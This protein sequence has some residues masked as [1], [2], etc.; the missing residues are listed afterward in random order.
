MKMKMKMKMENNLV[1]IFIIFL[2]CLS[3]VFIQLITPHF[4]AKSGKIIDGD[5]FTVEQCDGVRCY[6]LNKDGIINVPLKVGNIDIK[7]IIKI[8]STVKE[9]NIPNGIL[10]IGTEAC[11]LPEMISIK[12]PNSLQIIGDSAFKGSGLKAIEI[13]KSVIKI[14]KLA[15]YYNTDLSFIS[16]NEGLQSLGEGAFFYTKLKE[17]TLQLPLKIKES[18]V[19]FFNIKGDEN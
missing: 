6:D 11:M 18:Q 16:L 4:D 9:V 3:I 10:K 5:G 19:E 13:P 14:G 7:T 2:F 17:N 8:E 1:Y 15:F 12:L